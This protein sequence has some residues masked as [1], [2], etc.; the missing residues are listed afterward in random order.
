[1]KRFLF[2]LPGLALLGGC[3][4]GKPDMPDKHSDHEPIFDLTGR[5]PGKME[6]LAQQTGAAQSSYPTK[7]TV[8]A[9][10]KALITDSAASNATKQAAMSTIRDYAFSGGFTITIGD[11]SDVKFGT[12]P[13]LDDTK[14]NGDTNYLWS[15]DKI[16]DQLAGK[17]ATLVSGTTIKTVNNTSL[18]GSGNIDIAGGSFA[19]DTFPTYEDS[20]HSS[21]IAV[22]AT[23]LAI[24]S[25]A[26]N[27]WMTVGLT[28][29]LDP[30]PV[31]YAAT[32][33]ITDAGLTGDTFTLN[34]IAYDFSDSPVSVTNLPTATEQI[35]YTGSNTATCTGDVT[36]TGPWAINADPATVGCT[37]TA[38]ASCSDTPVIAET[39]Q[40]GNIQLTS[41]ST[42][43]Y[44]GGYWTGSSFS[45]CK[46]AVT[47]RKWV[48]DTSSKVYQVSVYS[49]N[50]TAIG[51]AKGHSATV[52]GFNSA[53]VTQVEFTFSSPVSVSTGDIIAFHEETPAADSTN[54]LRV[55]NNT[56]RDSEFDYSSFGTNLA[57]NGGI[58]DTVTPSITLYPYQ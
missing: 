1:M 31:T 14:G 51:T 27:K 37:V 34:S 56:A 41:S 16:Y 13:W 55:Y 10:D 21:G 18:L 33:T 38:P 54:Y 29:T 6:Q 42:N 52:T 12:D 3:A 43:A 40:A 36:G 11:L 44:A 24:Y 17:Q 47:M 48:G 46:A 22:N 50:G 2:V 23:T 25:T 8:V 53:T 19:F 15:A 7:T 35:T 49:P 32:L 20:P 57:R 58:S 26:A 28:D 5:K 39:S 9:G 45:L 4:C 30:T